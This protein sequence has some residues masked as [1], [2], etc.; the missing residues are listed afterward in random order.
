MKLLKHLLITF[1]LFPVILFGQIKQVQINDYTEY[2]IWVTINADTDQGEVTDLH[3]NYNIITSLP[4]EMKVL[5]AKYTTLFPDYILDRIDNEAL[6][7]CFGKYPT[8]NDVQKKLV[9]SWSNKIL[10]PERHFSY[11][12]IKRIKSEYFIYYYI[13]SLGI[14]EYYKLNTT[15][16]KITYEKITKF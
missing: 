3:I 14:E 15:K 13:T 8:L 11:L 4:F 9:T 5:I 10:L 1:F 7:K 2:E 16:G 12:K 6:A